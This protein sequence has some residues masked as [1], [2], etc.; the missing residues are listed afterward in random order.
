M[1]SSAPAPA[2]ARSP[3]VSP[4]PAARSWCW[5]RAATRAAARWRRACP[6]TTTSRP[7]IPSP[8]KTRRCA[9]DFFV[10]HY[11]DE[12]R[13]ARDPKF[14]RDGRRALSARR[15]AGRLHRAQR[16]DLHL[17]A[18]CPT[19]TASPALTGDHRWRAARMQRYFRA[20][21]GLPP[22]PVLARAGRL[23]H[24]SDRPWLGRLAADRDGAPA[25]RRSGTTADASRA[26]FGAAACAST[27]GL[28]RCSALW[29]TRGRGRS[30]TTAA[31][32]ASATKACATRRSARAATAASARA[33]ALL[34]VAARHPDR[35][36]IEAR[37]AGDPRAVRHGQSRRRRRVS[38]R[39][40]GS[41]A[42]TPRRP[43]GPG[44]RAGCARAARS[45][46]GRRRLQ[47]AAAADAVGHR[48]AR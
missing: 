41:T 26:S 2:A 22:S 35:L 19:G 48:A 44:E 27:G 13:Q 47:H 32:A 6:R 39:A 30:R 31:S 1:S 9:W 14:G 28:G 46:P 29:R 24:R 36:R 43:Y 21:R 17:P 11:A 12:A 20:D 40:R 38:A 34:D 15:H 33:S 25:L 23:R 37:R 16:D 42:R 45:D 18:R 4:R 10:R 7:S 5:R 3:R 8:P